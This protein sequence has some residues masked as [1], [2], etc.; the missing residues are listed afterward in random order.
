MQT[1]TVAPIPGTIRAPSAQ[2]APNVLAIGK[3]GP[4]EGRP[5]MQAQ[6]GILS[7]CAPETSDFKGHPQERL[8]ASAAQPCAQTACLGSQVPSLYARCLLSEWSVQTTPEHCLHG[9]RGDHGSL[10][11]ASLGSVCLL[12]NHFCGRFLDPTQ[13]F[14]FLDPSSFFHPV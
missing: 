9:N 1:G 2:R 8:W 13:L 14:C 11:P 6:T 10:N 4:L 12:F 3:G 7:T 5:T